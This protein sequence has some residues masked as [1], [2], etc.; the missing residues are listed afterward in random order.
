VAPDR[1]LQQTQRGLILLL[2]QEKVNHLFGLIHSTI[3]GGVLHMELY[4]IAPGTRP[5]IKGGWAI[6]LALESTAVPGVNQMVDMVHRHLYIA[7]QNRP[8]F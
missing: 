6:A 8:S 3:E 4:H 7:C 2:D 1:L 5:P